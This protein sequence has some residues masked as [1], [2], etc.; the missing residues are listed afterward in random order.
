MSP[1]PLAA[2]IIAAEFNPVALDTVCAT[3]MGF[4]YKKIPLLAKAW[5][6]DH[7][8]L[9]AISV[10]DIVCWSNVADWSGSLVDIEQSPH[11]NFDPQ[12]GWIGHI[13]R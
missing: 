6:I 10:S 5:K 11:L 1:E 4:D 8:P 13:E 7:Y 2:G 12:F 9:V 3:I